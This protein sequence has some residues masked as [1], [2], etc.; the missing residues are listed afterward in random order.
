MIWGPE[1]SKTNLIGSELGQEKDISKELLHDCGLPVPR[2]EVAYGLEEALD[3]ADHI[4]YPVVMKPVDGH[5]GEGVMVNLRTPEEL[6]KAYEITSEYSKYML[7]EKYI[8]GDDYR[9]LLINNEIAAVARRIP[10]MVVGDGSS[11]I[12]ELVESTNRDPNRGEGHNYPLTQLKLEQEEKMCLSHQ[13]LTEEYI[14]PEDKKIYLR[15]VAN[16]STGGTAEDCTDLIHSSLKRR[17]ERASKIID[18][19]VM[20]I[21]I[22]AEDISNP[23]EEMSWSIIEVN[24]SPGLRMHLSPTEGESRPVGEKIIDNLFPTGN[25]RIPTIAITGTNGKT[26][27]A[28]LTDRIARYRGLH[29]GLAVTGGIWC[30]GDLIEKGDTTGPWSANVVLQDPEVQMAILETARGGIL[31]RG[32]GFDRCDVSVVTNIREDHLGVDDIE[33]IEDLFWIKSILLETTAE[34][35]FCVINAE[36]GF[37]PR[38]IEKANGTPI[39]FANEKN[40]LLA[41]H[42]SSGGTAFFRQED[43][44]IAC[45]DGDRIPLARLDEFPYLSNGARMLV[46]NALAAL[47]TSY[48]AGIPLKTI[49]EALK[50]FEMNEEM[51]P[52]RLNTYDIEGVKVIFDYAHNVNGLEALAEYVSCLSA[53]N[54]ILLYTGLGDRLDESIRKNGE[55][56]AERFDKIVFSEKE[57]QLR[58]RDNGMIQALLNEGAFRKG[59]TGIIILD[60]DDALHFVLDQ[61]KPSDIVVSANLDFTSEDLDAYLAGKNEEKDKVEE[62]HH[63]TDL[64]NEQVF[65][66]VD[67]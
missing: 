54:T 51:N 15:S 61:A 42:V 40:N 2:G 63:I 32:L 12:K 60:P 20:G 3:I 33:D 22:I 39:L 10:A 16:I 59:K 45:I 48:A 34:D 36:D 25:G 4:G 1:T 23:I 6:K 26:T 52:G 37:A 19:D 11:T 27:T 67:G 17:L 29:T 65:E 66:K 8:Q 38:L 55:T 28:R 62:V 14:P 43:E 44:I 5:H 30:G 31:R 21:D 18:M 9:V 58:G 46:E 50:T 7:I 47:A 53:E 13:G 64:S 49:V 24:S 57:D 35:G 56:A 41:E